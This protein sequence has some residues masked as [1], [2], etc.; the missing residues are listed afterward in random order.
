MGT[1]KAGEEQIRNI[2]QNTSGTY[3]IS[4]PKK[5][6]SELEWRQGQKVVVTKSG[7][8]LIISDWKK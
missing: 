3:Q 8:S 6:V 1:R 5:L 2:T 7:K 4:I